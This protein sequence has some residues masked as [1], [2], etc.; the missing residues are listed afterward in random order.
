MLAAALL[1][2]TAAG[3]APSSPLDY[4]AKAPVR[5]E[6]REVSR[7]DGRVEYEVKFPSPL[8]SPFAANDTV[9]AHYSVPDSSGVHPCILVL[10]VMAAPNIWIE[11][12]FMKRF[13][14]DGFGVLWLEM[15]Y[16]FHRR[17]DSSQPSGQVF[18]ARTA[19]RLAFNFRQS[20]LDARRAL[21]WLSSR[22]EVDRGRI[23]LF[24]V[25]LGAM[26]AAAAY[27]VDPAPKYA[28]FMLGG[29]DFPDLIG[30]SSMT[31]PFLRRSRI[32][33][34]ALR[35]AMAGL[36]P[37]DYAAANAGKPALLVNVR[38]DTVVPRANALKLKAAF[39]L[40]RQVWLPLGHYTAILHLFWVPGMISRDFQAH[41]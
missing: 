34:A 37:T 15:P 9:W 26:V 2:A 6:L 38:W 19:K 18:L 16:Q 17:P 36:D 10:P 11:E 25:S 33:P 1:L 40:S 41:L 23:G 22:P 29:A 4:D 13:R 39:P 24:G 12:R 35:P 31:E 28:V 32:D 7:R 30:H 3:A 8:K 21:A 27:S 20:A 14:R 5:A